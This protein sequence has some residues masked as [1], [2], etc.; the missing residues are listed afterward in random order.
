M[1]HKH[2]T[3]YQSQDEDGDEDTLALVVYP[4][5]NDAGEETESDYGVD[6]RWERILD[7]KVKL[8]ERVAQELTKLQV[9]EI[10]L[11]M[12]K[13]LFE[14]QVCSC[15][16][17]LAFLCAWMGLKSSSKIE[18]VSV[19]R[20]FLNA[21][22][23]ISKKYLYTSV[24]E[25][26]FT[27]QV[28]PFLRDEVFMGPTSRPAYRVL[29]AGSVEAFLKHNGSELTDDKIDRFIK[30]GLF[31]TEKFMK[32]VKVRLADSRI[33]R[34]IENGR[35]IRPY[36]VFEATGNF[37]N[38]DTEQEEQDLLLAKREFCFSWAKLVK[39]DLVSA[40]S[41]EDNYNKQ[42]GSKRMMVKAIADVFTKGQWPGN[43]L[44]K[45][46]NAKLSK[47]AKEA[48][49]Q[50]KKEQDAIEKARTKKRQKQIQGE[51]KAEKTITD[52]TFDAVTITNNSEKELVKHSS[53]LAKTPAWWTERPSDAAS[54]TV[55]MAHS[56]YF[57]TVGA[58]VT[59]KI[60]SPSMR[61]AP[62]E[63]TG[64][65]KISC[66]SS[67]WDSAVEPSLAKNIKKSLS[68]LPVSD[69]HP[70]WKNPF[71]RM[72]VYLGQEGNPAHP[73]IQ[74]L[75]LTSMANNEGMEYDIRMPL[76]RISMR[77][78]DAT[79]EQV[80]SRVVQDDEVGFARVMEQSLR[81]SELSKRPKIKSVVQEM[82]SV[83]L[84]HDSE[85]S[86]W[87]MDD[88]R[89][90]M[91]KGKSGTPRSGAVQ[92]ATHPSTAV[93]LT[94]KGNA[95]RIIFHSLRPQVKD[96]KLFREARRQKSELTA[97]TRL[98]EP[99]SDVE[100]EPGSD[101]K[102]K[103]RKFKRPTLQREELV[104]DLKTDSPIMKL[105]T[106]EAAVAYVTLKKPQ[107]LH[108]RCMIGLGQVH[109]TQELH[110]GE[111]V[112][113]ARLDMKTLLLHVTHARGEAV[114][115]EGKSKLSTSMASDLTFIRETLEGIEAF[116]P[117]H[118]DTLVNYSDRTGEESGIPMIIYR[119]LMLE[120]DSDQVRNEREIWSVRRLP[121]P[122]RANL[123]VLEAFR[124]GRKTD[125]VV[126]MLRW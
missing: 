41:A 125:A 16:H 26:F 53:Q 13:A 117:K 86:F 22:Q 87:S 24:R 71:T 118:T 37:R 107:T 4:L 47:I 115:A 20:G 82:S 10:K 14:G 42:G 52:T 95:A 73:F 121:T 34:Y 28:P 31:V 120:R 98:I 76:K 32:M 91:H 65:I 97:G 30:K 39:K 61:D 126:N 114:F 5:I 116:E 108:Y 80:I 104:V 94:R 70:L 90:L 43:E 44:K 23:G 60:T 100:D 106:W 54:E 102:K 75:L 40:K 45:D 7:G 68:K 93:A 123:R 21:S 84:D 63:S 11:A 74:D 33:Q 111:N 18:D 19:L 1:D 8:G 56:A 17:I 35:V 58:F 78:T 89:R 110:F 77:L 64:E 67:A 2:D 55:L 48:K 6:F 29:P 101:E 62:N 124:E 109:D 113:A 46:V 51:R 69:Q 96:L 99:E 92:L 38:T 88:A 85:R 72:E 25:H 119:S 83:P 79:A 81:G 105:W 122:S 50:A 103:S 27:A 15:K 12:T 59:T 57:H 66:A 36:A 3:G 9:H 112:L 49:K